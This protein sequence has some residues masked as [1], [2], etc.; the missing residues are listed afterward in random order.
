MREATTKATT[1]YGAEVAIPA[2]IDILVAGFVCKDL[3]RL[4]RNG[5]TLEDGGYTY[6]KRFRP[7][8]VL[9]ENVKSEKATWDDVVL[10]WNKIDYEAAWVFCDTKRYY[11]P[12]TRERMYMVA[13]ER[14]HFGKRANSAVSLWRTTMQQLERHCSSPYEAF[15]PKS[16]TESRG[17]SALRSEPDWAL[18]KLR[19]DHIRSEKR[20][21]ILRPVSRRNENGTVMYVDIQPLI[22][23]R[24]LTMTQAT[25]FCGPEVLQLP[26]VASS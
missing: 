12:Q 2:H 11:L 26:I 18:C 19:N 20:L 9:L 7:S 17:H 5:K 25:G 8:I 10:R 21:G 24:Q 15:L 4:N 13:I 23:R 3:S 6:A 16:S 22:L 14:S 1:A